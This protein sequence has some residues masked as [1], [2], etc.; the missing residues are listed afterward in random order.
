MT[1]SESGRGFPRVPPAAK[2][3]ISR[4]AVCLLLLGL[5]SMLIFA[6]TQ[7]LPGDVVQVLLGK[8]ATR[9]QID[10][11][12]AQLNLDKPVWQ[13]YLLWAGSALRGDLGVSFVS[14][15][16][17]SDILI[18]R[19]GNTVVIVI[20]SFLVS[21]PLALT[22][23][24]LSSL[25]SDGLLDRTR[26]LLG[27][28]LNALPEFVLALFLVLLLSTHVLHL[29]PAVSLLT[30]GVSAWL[31][32]PKLIL[33][34]LT[35]ALL[36]VSYLYRLVRAAMIDVLASDYIEFAR[37]KGIPPRQILL[38]HA[39]PN[40]VIPFVQ[41]TGTIFAISFGGVVV[42]EYV[43]AFPG[44]GTA[45]ASAVGSRDIQVVQAVTLT[46]AAIFFATN[47]VTDLVTLRLTPH[48]RGGSQ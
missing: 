26:M 35:L 15:V 24:I 8:D 14:G 1:R 17:V 42:I 32:P 38:R 27:I 29:L 4:I 21:V 39:L 20:L 30:P 10:A 33:P 6:A 36:Q 48:G 16:P 7:A 13:Q 25:R 18:S 40:A 11:I 43:F 47:I 22:L 31:Q 34:V 28:G 23:G 37:L 19:F 12:R 3:A 9:A 41:A 5:V 2:L 45:L 44:L 46:I